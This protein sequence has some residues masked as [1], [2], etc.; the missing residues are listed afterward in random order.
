MQA[1]AGAIENDT[2]NVVRLRAAACLG[3]L[4]PRAKAALVVLKKA[5]NDAHPAVAK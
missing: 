1:L 2:D 4:G 3:Y 5:E